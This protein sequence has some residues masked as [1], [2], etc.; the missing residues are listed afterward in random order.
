MQQYIN[1]RVFDGSGWLT[2]KVVTVNG[3]RVAGID[4]R[5][6]DDSEK[7]DCKGNMLVTG[8]IDLQLYGAGGRLFSAFPD[9]ES[10]TVLAEE[11]RKSGVVAC[12]ATIATQPKE[13][14]YACLDA[15]KKYRHNQGKGILGLHLEGPFLNAAKRGAHNP[16]WI[17]SPSADEVKELLEVADGVIRIVTIAPECCDDLVIQLFNDAGVCIS[18]GHSNATYGQAKEFSKRGVKLVTHLFNAMSALH[19]RDTGLPGAAFT[20]LNLFSSIIPDGI[21]VSY[22]AL[23]IAKKQMGERLFFITDSVTETREGAYQHTLKGDH[24]CTAD[25][26]LSGSAITMLQGIRNAIQNA[27]IGLE[28]SLCMATVYP[29]KALGIHND[30]GSIAVGKKADF[31]LLN[32]QLELVAN[33]IRV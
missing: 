32:D 31:I 25:G 17:H 5:A 23:Q 2:G 29:A 27:G 19:H 12:L 21:H 11:N 33:Y 16:A 14:I 22:P 15:L 6:D 20:D 4:D 9:E 26:T 3:D 18:A 13:V 1:A 30:Y 10:L 8:L 7:I 24:Y 28:E